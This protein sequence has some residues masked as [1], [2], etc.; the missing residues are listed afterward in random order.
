[1]DCNCSLA[2]ASY[3]V[4][5]LYHFPSSSGMVGAPSRRVD[6]IVEAGKQIE[7]ESPG[8]DKSGKATGYDVYVAT[9]P[10]GSSPNRP[11]TLQA[12]NIPFGTNW[13]E[14]RSGL[15][16][17]ATLPPVLNT[18]D[19]N[20]GRIQLNFNT[21][22]PRGVSITVSYAYNG[23]MSGGTGLMDEDGRSAHQA[24]L[25]SDFIYLS[26]TN[27]NVKA[28][29][30]A[31]LFAVASQY[32]GTCQR[33]IKKAFPNTLFLG[34]DS[35]GSW[36]A[37]ARVPVMQAAGKY[38]DV[39]SAPG[40]YD[41]RQGVIDYTA[42]YFGDK[43][44]LEGQYRTANPSSPWSAHPGGGTDFSTQEARGQD[45][46]NAVT[47]LQSKAVTATGS[48]PFVGEAWWQ[49]TDNRG[50]QKNWGL[51]TLLDNAYDGHEDVS[52]IVKCSPPLQSYS[53]GG[54]AA[55]YGDV[56]RSVK[57]ANLFWLT[58]QSEI[59]GNLPHD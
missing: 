35:I 4:R 43:P 54:E 7:V 39:L 34:P 25:G 31:F 18:I 56:I 29:F 40:H 16:D 36:G 2:A 22:P 37:P 17:G 1:M 51:V 10:A 11:E 21:P 28:D 20:S 27:P 53:C 5:I 52:G 33:E 42:Q 45:Y 55:N 47:G 15:I 19:Y 12:S 49:Y 14:P 23:W 13:V 50:E 38:V 6:I 8:P 3:W 48:H 41:T 57:S 59:T 58:H 26:N 30:D 46:Y 44:V 9:G 32:L 24:W